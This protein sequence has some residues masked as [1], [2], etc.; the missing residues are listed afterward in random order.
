MK[1]ESGDELSLSDAIRDGECGKCGSQLRHQD[2]DPDP[3]GP[4]W[5]MECGGCGKRYLFSASKIRV[6]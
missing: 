3:D 6:I 4:T 2:F 1:L 5:R